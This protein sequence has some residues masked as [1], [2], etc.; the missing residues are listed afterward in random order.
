MKCYIVDTNAILRFLLHDV[1]KQPEKVK[2]LF[3]RARSEKVRLVVPQIVI[4]EIVFALNKYYNLPKS[5]I[6]SHL[7]SILA[8]EYLEIQD[9]EVFGEA[10]KL[11]EKH[12][13]DFV[14]CFLTAYARR[15]ESEI[16]SFDKDLKKLTL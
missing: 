4:F 1:P 9:R 14:D 13:I 15:Q 2:N 8:A 5:D 16:F 7:K 6:S 10:I 3:V 12:S 11:L